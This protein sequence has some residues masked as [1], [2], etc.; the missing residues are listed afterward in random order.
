MSFNSDK[1]KSICSNS[2]N[3]SK[4][5][6]DK[7]QLSSTE[8]FFINNSN[9]IAGL[10]WGSSLISIILFC[11]SFVRNNQLSSSYNIILGLGIIFSYLL[12]VLSDK[13]NNNL[14]KK[15][16]NLHFFSE[17]ILILSK[18][19]PSLNM[20]FEID[21]KMINIDTKDVN[22]EKTVESFK[23]MLFSDIGDSKKDKIINL[24]NYKKVNSI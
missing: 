20:F 3:I 17:Q 5:D 12:S 19:Y 16:K 18:K 14:N 11:F 15:I 21:D 22:D 2:P 6:I 9:K 1:T 8:V 7:L 4:N 24:Q 13:F 10:T 23:P